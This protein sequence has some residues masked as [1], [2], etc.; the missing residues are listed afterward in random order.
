MLICAK[1]RVAKTTGAG[2]LIIVIFWFSSACFAQTT[3]GFYDFV[4]EQSQ[5]HYTEVPHEVLALYYGWYGEMK[6]TPTGVIDR[7]WEQVN[8]NKHEIRK[9]AHYPINGPY[10]SHNT[11][12]LDWQIDQAKSHG[13]TGFVVSWSGTGP[14]ASWQEKSLQILLERAEKKNF[15]ISIY[16]EQAPS[17]GRGQIE[18]AIGEISYVLTRYGKSPVFLKV[19]GKPVI[20]AYGRLIYQVPVAAWP[21]I[22][23]G[24]RAKA[25]DFALIADGHQQSYVDLFDGIHSYGLDGLPI[26]LERKLTN[27]KLTNLRSWAAQYYDRGVKMSR[28]ESRISCLDVVP[29]SDQ[30]RAYNFDWQTDRL[31]GETYRVLWEEAIR[32][33]PDWVIITSWNE[34]PEG[35]EIE[36]SLELGDKYLQITAEY[37]KHFMDSPPIKVPPPAEVLPKFVPGTSLDAST[38]LARRK[39]AILMEDRFNDSEFWAAYCGAKLER[40]TW[41]SLIDSKEFNAGNFPI[42]ICIGKEHYRSSVKVTDDVRAAL[43]RY[44]HQGGFLVSLP[45]GTWPMLYDD[46]RSGIP[47][48]ITDTLDLGVDNGFE[49]PPS[50]AQLTFYVNTNALRGLPATAPFPSGGDLRW[51]PSSRTRVPAYDYYVPLVTLL[52]SDR[53]SYNQGA[54]YIQ[55]RT[56]PISPGKTVYVWMRT[57]EAFGPDEFYPSLFQFISTKLKPATEAK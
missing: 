50:R 29:G 15:K 25:G 41:T 34:W 10:S 43:I 30:R 53:H 11:E 7:A 26:D 42:L 57:A 22:M 14:E 55:H 44:L 36:P 37:S 6:E 40:L 18:R 9:T 5:R 16:W 49:E 32:A 8:T 56:L 2:L 27:D 17:E 13:I 48:G 1:R 47:H 24:I 51:R 38:L 23:R 46:S 28:R 19:D 52:D 39:V 33:K 3:N 31:N 4:Q 45:T 35:T 21:E 54:V 12:I 20:F